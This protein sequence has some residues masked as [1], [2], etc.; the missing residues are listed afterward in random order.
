M[1]ELSGDRGHVRTEERE[2]SD[3]AKAK[4]EKRK[5]N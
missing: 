3:I 5:N 4:S 1:K 2:M